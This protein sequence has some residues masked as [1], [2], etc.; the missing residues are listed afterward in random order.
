MVDVNS[1]SSLEDNKRTELFSSI[2]DVGNRIMINFRGL[3]P[4]VKASNIIVLGMK[5]AGKTTLWHGLGGIETVKRDTLI[6]EIP[7]FIFQL[8]NGRRVRVVREVKRKVPGK[9]HAKKTIVGGGIDIGG[10]DSYVYKY[11][12]LIVQD[13]FV[14]YIA[15]AT[16]IHDYQYWRR[17][18]ADFRKI[19]SVVTDKRKKIGKKHFGFK[20]LLSHYDEWLKTHPDSNYLELYELFYNKMKGVKPEGPIGSHFLD[21]DEN[22]LMVINLLNDNEIE[23]IK[24]EI[25][26]V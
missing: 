8:D 25:S 10:E 18:R 22:V 24:E 9:S 14:Y 15:D 21:R 11:E 19:D 12:D 23:V 26:K 1:E 16:R 5:G 17:M 2:V 7:S 13:S 6:V 20:V 4:P 3:L